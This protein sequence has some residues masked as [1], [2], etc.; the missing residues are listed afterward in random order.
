MSCCLLSTPS[1]TT[2]FTTT[3]LQI[4]DEPAPC[5]QSP[6]RL[7]WNAD[8]NREREGHQIESGGFSQYEYQRDLRERN[9]ENIAA[10]HWNPKRPRQQSIP[11]STTD[12]SGQSYSHY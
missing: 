4:N 11:L 1:A 12:L 2:T 8:D 9:K 7:L 6:T 3:Q 5:R 10:A